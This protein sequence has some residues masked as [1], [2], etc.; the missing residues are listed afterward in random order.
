MGTCS[1]CQ[2]RCVNGRWFS[3]DYSRWGAAIRY[4]N[5]SLT[6]PLTVRWQGKSIWQEQK[7]LILL[8]SSPWCQRRMSTEYK[9]FNRTK[10]QCK[11]R[12]KSL[13]VRWRF[14]WRPLV[15]PRKDDLWKRWFQMK[16]FRMSRFPI[17]SATSMVLFTP[18]RFT[19]SREAGRQQKKKWSVCSWRMPCGDN[20]LNVK[21]KMAWQE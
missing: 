8:N 5:S 3:S 9:R 17:S 12:K 20:C 13:G 18:W 15:S 11:W 4:L 14:R 21:R 10:K 1:G 2:R 16:R 7:V 6:P 19:F